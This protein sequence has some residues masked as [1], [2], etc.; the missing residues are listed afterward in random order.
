MSKKREMLH[1]PTLTFFRCFAVGQRES[2]KMLAWVS[3]TL[4]C[5]CPAAHTLDARDGLVCG[6]YDVEVSGAL[7]HERSCVQIPVGQGE[8]QSSW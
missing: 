7:P 2:D 3:L 1:F 8:D 4:I 5:V 6:R